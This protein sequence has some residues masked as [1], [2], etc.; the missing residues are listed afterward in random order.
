[1]L[2]VLFVHDFLDLGIGLV[3]ALGAELDELLRTFE[4]SAERV[5]IEFLVLHF[6]DDGFQFSHRLFVFDCFVH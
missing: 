6:L 4:I 2:R 3:Q 1:M 5:K